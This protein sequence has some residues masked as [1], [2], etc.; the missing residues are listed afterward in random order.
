M[1]SVE[2]VLGQDPDNVLQL[3]A[4]LD[5]ATH[6][7]VAD[8]IIAAAWVKGLALEMP[9]SV[10]ETAGCVRGALSG[11]VARVGSH[12][13][14]RGA[15]SPTTWEV[16]ALRQALWRSALSVFLSVE[17][18]IIGALL[19]GDEVR[20]D[21]PGTVQALHRLGL[22]RI[23]MLTRDRA[24]A[25][26]TNAAALNIVMVLA[27]LEDGAQRKKHGKWHPP[28]SKNCLMIIPPSTLHWTVCASL[29]IR[30]KTPRHIQPHLL[31]KRCSK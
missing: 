10:R 5:Q 22:S 3:A 15:Q 21:A 9:S 12:A 16:R 25:A 23:T 4:S 20:Q 2:T 24:E 7:V 14:L 26:E 18:N 30:L 28:R 1:L 8:A 6:H 11:K 17:G 13:F 31:S 27:N 29:Q 19:L